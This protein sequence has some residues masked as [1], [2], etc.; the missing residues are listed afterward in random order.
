MSPS[1]DSSLPA[2]SRR[3]FRAALLAVLCWTVVLGGCATFQSSSDSSSGEADEAPTDT[4]AGGAAL[5][6]AGLRADSLVA[7]TVP[8]AVSDSLRADTLA[9]ADTSDRPA[10]DADSMRRITPE[11]TIPSG[12]AATE[13]PERAYVQADSLVNRTTDDGQR[14][15]ELSRNVFVEQ[16]STRLRS[17]DAVHFLSRKEFLFFGDVEIFERGDTLYADTVRYDRR[18][19]V[20]RAFGR[21]QLTDGEVDVYSRR[22]IYYSEEKRSVFPDSVLLVDGSRT[23]RAESGVYYSDEQRADF[24]GNVQ[25]RDP[26]TY[27]EADTVIYYREEERSDARGD[28]FI[29]RNPGRRAADDRMTGYDSLRARAGDTRADARAGDAEDEEAERT[30]DDT[31]DQTLLWGNRA[32]NDERSKS[33]R[34]T[35]RALLLQVRTDSARA[36]TD[37]LL[38]RSHRLNATRSDTLDRMVAIDSV[39]IWQPDLAAVA[40]S[41]VYDRFKAP[42]ASQAAPGADSPIADAGDA[43]GD[44]TLPDSARAADA[45]G[46]P[47]EE[48]EEEGDAAPTLEETRL[49]RG[50]M[51]WFDGSQ[52]SGD[53]I[54]VVVRNRSVDT[55]FVRS[56]AFAAQ[57]DTTSGRIQQLSGQQITAHF[58]LDSLRRIVAE[59]N[60]R[61]IRFMTGRDGEANGAARTSADRIVLRFRNDEVE[62]V[63]VLG[64]TETTYYKEAIIPA[65]FELDGFIWT[66][67]RRPEK[68]DFLEDRRVRT[69]L[70]PDQSLPPD[71]TAPDT[72]A[73]DTTAPNITTPDSTAPDTSRMAAT[74]DTAAE[75]SSAEESAERPSGPQAERSDSSVPPSTDPLETDPVETD[76]AGESASRSAPPR[77]SPP[78]TARR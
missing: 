52:V 75:E 44:D 34:V 28:V 6:S 61:A 21:V 60:A 27:M 13:T 71:T 36:P 49:F 62:R 74:E 33:S 23:L 65:S 11:D 56:S 9:A 48:R 19:K 57:E 68:A 30:G 76:P 43:G 58:R 63:S 17:R 69:R 20:G 3:R 55:V 53:T 10:I 45:N 12:D 25:V 16:D 5:D 7:D 1:S 46:T 2:A 31:D 41:V 37:T 15:Q 40:D 8:G 70:A 18:A 73:P 24:F 26:D 42:A 22:A 66:P 64:G 50:P 54:R 47:A 67:E 14:V 77:T 38:V 78:K 29:D 72:T 35:G 4:L 32:E 39:R 59:P 51:A